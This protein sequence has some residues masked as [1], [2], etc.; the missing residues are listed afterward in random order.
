MS[1]PGHSSDDWPALA[2]SALKGGDPAGLRWQDASGLSREPAYFDRP[3]QGEAVVKTCGWSIRPVLSLKEVAEATAHGADQLSLTEAGYDRPHYRENVGPGCPAEN[4]VLG[5]DFDPLLWS[6][7][8]TARA[9]M[10]GGSRVSL[11]GALMREA[12]ANPLQEITW[13]AAAFNEFMAEFSADQV[14]IRTGCGSD[15]FT[16]MAKM[17][18]LRKLLT[19]VDGACPPL[20]AINLLL[21]YT[22]RDPYPNLLRA[23]TAGMAAVMGGC[24]SLTLRPYHPQDPSSLRL[25]LHQQHLM[26]H[27]SYLDQVSDPGAG[28]YAVEHFTE[29]LVQEALRG[30]EAIEK[31][32][33]FQRWYQSGGAKSQIALPGDR[34]LVGG[35]RYPSPDPVEVT[36]CQPALPSLLSDGYRRLEQEEARA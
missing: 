25:S 28:S 21:E 6:D 7:L 4:N 33:G 24:D 26:V 32:G 9:W 36:F 22:G 8:D 30:G 3:A 13:L 23:T 16:E 35:N 1:F 20:H 15:F 11:N 2:R 5:V 34:I 12:G 19:G 17:R 27:E 10:A 14:E 29:S 18:A 31:A